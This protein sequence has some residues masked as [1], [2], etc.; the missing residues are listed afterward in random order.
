MHLG[1]K[2]VQSK[3]GFMCATYRTSKCFCACVGACACDSMPPERLPDVSFC[4]SLK[5]K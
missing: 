5:R 1:S 3:V 2:N 4:F